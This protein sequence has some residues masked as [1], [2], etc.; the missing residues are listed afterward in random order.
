MA[1]LIDDVY[2]RT[3]IPPLPATPQFDNAVSRAL[4][5]RAQVEGRPPE[6]ASYQTA[7]IAKALDSVATVANANGVDQQ[8]LLAANPQLGSS[9]FLAPGEVVF[10][11]HKSP[12]SAQT[13]KLIDDAVRFDRE[14]P[15]DVA[16]S[17]ANWQRVQD[18][19]VGD[20]RSSATG[21]PDPAK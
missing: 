19:I 16:G 3:Y 1:L 13:E 8:Q 4:T 10:I 17:D 21:Q 14:H 18:S 15:G 11:P 5:R 12:V 20:I 6:A 2:F 9:G 7:Y